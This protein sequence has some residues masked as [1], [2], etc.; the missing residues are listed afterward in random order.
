MNEKERFAKAIE[1]LVQLEKWAE[2]PDP[3]LSPPS[4]IGLS[5]WPP[6]P[7]RRPV[8]NQVRLIKHLLETDDERKE[9]EKKWCDWGKRFQVCCDGIREEKNK[10]GNIHN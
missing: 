8:L 5:D 2:S 3:V 9:T 1:L 7:P 4:P 10:E 6:I